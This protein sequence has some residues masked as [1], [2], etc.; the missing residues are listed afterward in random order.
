MGLH[1]IRIVG[2]RSDFLSVG[3]NDILFSIKNRS[4]YKWAIAW[5]DGIGLEGTFFEKF[6]KEINDAV[7]VLP[8]TLEELI[9]IASKID[10]LFDVMIIADRSIDNLRKFNNFEEAST[11]C[12]LVLELIDSSYWLITSKNKEFLIEMAEGFEGVI[13]DPV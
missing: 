4:D 10:Q 3:L 1:T 5:I 9:I 8:V 13:W 7:T 11:T 12:A 6:S 2:S